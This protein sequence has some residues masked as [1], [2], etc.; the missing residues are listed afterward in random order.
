VASEPGA[1]DLVLA[2]SRHAAA[3]EQ[4]GP[5]RPCAID[6]N[7]TF[8]CGGSSAVA[9][10]EWQRGRGWH[11]LLA[12]D[13]AR[14]AL[15]DLYLPI[16]SAV[17]ER[18]VVLGHL[19]Q[20]LD[21]FIA[22]HG[23]DS[24]WVTGPDN[25]LHLHRLR[26]LCDAVVVGALTVAADDPQLT[27]RHV[28]G[29]N[30]LRIIFDPTRRLDTGYA[31]FQRTD[32][33][34]LYACAS[35]LVGAAETHVGAAA[36]VGLPA[37]E[38]GSH[39]PALMR[40]LRALGCHR[41]LVEGGGVTVSGFLQAGLLDRLHL[42]VAPLFI[43]DG[44]PAIRLPGEASLEACRRPA[45]RVFR[46]GGDMLFDCDLRAAAEPEARGGDERLSRVI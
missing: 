26:A 1:W 39:V 15:V 13:D 9:V 24:R 34:T 10:L 2:A 46:M 11:S 40:H 32:A 33:P 14:S 8:V 28:S 31:V 35:S 22:T 44:R 20:S 6:A 42:T 23:G 45:Y 16:C 38:S 27:T 17:P 5:D 4:A 21:G 7:G 18:P 37:D 12:S 29:P 19:G 25:I 41:T 30:P 36:I 3:A 43:G